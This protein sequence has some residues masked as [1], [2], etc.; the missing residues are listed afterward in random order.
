MG[1]GARGH[2]MDAPIRIPLLIFRGAFAAA[3]ASQRKL[4]RRP[5]RPGCRGDLADIRGRRDP[6]RSHLPDHSGRR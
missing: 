2:G 6:R 1:I 5:R 3:D 4:L